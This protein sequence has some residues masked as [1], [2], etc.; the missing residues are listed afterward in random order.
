VIKRGE[1]TVGVEIPRRHVEALSREAIG[2]E[3]LHLDLEIEGIEEVPIAQV[4][5]A[6]GQSSLTGLETA[7]GLSKEGEIDGICFMPFNKE[8]MHLGGNPFMDE[9]QHSANGWV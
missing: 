4:S 2:D 9:K 3:I 1:E 7:F 8:S 6:G 5:A